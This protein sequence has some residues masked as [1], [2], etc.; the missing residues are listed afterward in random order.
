MSF[1]EPQ[2]RDN[3]EKNV[4]APK[5]DEALLGALKD[6]ILQENLTAGELLTRTHEAAK[7]YSGPIREIFFNNAT[8]VPMLDDARK[9]GQTTFNTLTRQVEEASSKLASSQQ[10]KAAKGPGS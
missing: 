7:S 8:Y 6:Y 9:K 2:K 5:F 4:N 3:Y 10:I 1:K